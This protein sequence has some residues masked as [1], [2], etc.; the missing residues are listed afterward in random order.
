MKWSPAWST[1]ITLID[2]QHQMLFKMSEDYQS[3]LEA[4]TGQHVYAGLLTSLELYVGT[5]FRYE[6]GCMAR[7]V[8]PAAARNIEAHAHFSETLARFRRRHSE[9]GFVRE[10]AITLMHN[11]DDWLVK[12][13]CSIDVQMKKLVDPA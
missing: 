6:E 8:C 1:G 2:E 9:T 13:I 7:L 3:A 4:G 10:D 12:H 5:H 11:I